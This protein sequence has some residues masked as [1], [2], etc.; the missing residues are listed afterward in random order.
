MKNFSGP[1]CGI[2][3][4]VCI[5]SAL[6]S[7][8][9]NI[10]ILRLTSIKCFNLNNIM[11]L[12]SDGIGIGLFNIC[13]TDAGGDQYGHLSTN[14]LTTLHF[15]QHNNH[16]V[17]SIHMIGLHWEYENVSTEMQTN[18]E[19]SPFHAYWVIG[20]SIINLPKVCLAWKT[21]NTHVEH[22]I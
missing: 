5:I 1:Q 4:F 7:S 8:F 12:I 3:I 11:L 9:T 18:M 20:P 2:K 21:N 10:T 6:L 14:S 22:Q 15:L 16:P 19:S 17:P 13:F